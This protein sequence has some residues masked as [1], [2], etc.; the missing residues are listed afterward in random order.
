MKA[1]WKF[2]LTPAGAEHLAAARA[3]PAHAKVLS[4]GQQNDKLMIWAQ[5]DTDLERD[6]G[7]R[8]FHVF[9][10]GHDLP[11]AGLGDFLGTVHLHGGRIVVHIFDMP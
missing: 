2:E 3:M 5:I 1:I 6:G 11:G 8:Y 10:T 9:G 4:V 7:T